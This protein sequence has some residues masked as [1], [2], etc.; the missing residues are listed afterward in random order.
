RPLRVYFFSGAAVPMFTSSAEY[1][2]IFGS[3]C[4][5]MTT[6]APTFRSAFLAGLSL[7][8]YFVPF[9]NMIT[10]GLLSLSFIVNV[11]FETAVTVPIIGSPCASNNPVNKAIM[12]KQTANRFNIVVF[13]LMMVFVTIL[14]ICFISSDSPFNAVDASSAYAQRH[15]QL[16]GFEGKL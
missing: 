15:S 12:T 9:S 5:S 7:I 10:T 2:F 13:S 3:M 8:R 11:S 1:I 6:L 14:W 4:A 16:V